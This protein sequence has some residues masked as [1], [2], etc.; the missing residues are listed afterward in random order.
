MI[1]EAVGLPVLR[2][3]EMP[4]AEIA[5]WEGWFKLKAHEAKRSANRQQARSRP[6]GRRGRR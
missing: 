5:I 1:A 6:K 3:L 2:V 4:T